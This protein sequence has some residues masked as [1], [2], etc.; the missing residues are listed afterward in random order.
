MNSPLYGV[1]TGIDPD[2]T[3]R[4]A[5]RTSTGTMRVE[6]ATRDTTLALEVTKDGAFTV[7]YSPYTWQK[8][9]EAGTWK[10]VAQGTVRNSGLEVNHA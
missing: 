7:L 4:H 3:I 5:S 8:S 1:V 10:V 9:Q 2:G 6:I